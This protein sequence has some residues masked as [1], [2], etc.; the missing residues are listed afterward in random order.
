MDWIEPAHTDL[1]LTR[2][3]ELTGV[4]RATVYRRLEAMAR[5]QYDGQEDNA[6]RALI[7]EQYTSRPFYGSRRMAV[8]LQGQGHRVNR[9]RVQR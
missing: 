2:Q 4:P 1:P 9:K 5:E 7:D 8:F 6:L 3:C